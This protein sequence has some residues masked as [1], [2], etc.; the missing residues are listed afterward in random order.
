MLSRYRK[1][2]RK[3]FTWEQMTK[4]KEHIAAGYSIKATARFVGVCEATLRKRLKEVC[5]FYLHRLAYA[6]N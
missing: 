5:S 2:N 3:Q 1:S 4:A 6:L